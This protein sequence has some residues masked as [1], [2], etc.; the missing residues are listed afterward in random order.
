MYKVKS[1]TIKTVLPV[2]IILTLSCGKN[3]GVDQK[4]VENKI[5]TEKK[6]DNL[7]HEFALISETTS[8]SVSAK[9]NNL[10]S[11][12]KETCPEEFK[13][14]GRARKEI[15]AIRSSI[16]KNSRSNLKPKEWKEIYEN[17]KNTLKSKK[18]YLEECLNDN[19]KKDLTHEISDI[20]KACRLK[21]KDY[22][23]FMKLEKKEDKNKNKLSKK[24]I[25]TLNSLKTL[26]SKKLRS[27]ECTRVL[28]IDI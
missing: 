15:K 22:Q 26:R 20:K 7:T 17:K 10:R 14:Y 3:R 2:F 28:D 27:S 21:H 19:N 18:I 12:I 11:E 16:K 1:K 23:K 25:K 5:N 24:E 4:G 8:K 6:L 9:I 13:L